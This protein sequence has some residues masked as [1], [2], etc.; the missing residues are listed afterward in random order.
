MLTAPTRRPALRG[1]VPRPR[2]RVIPQ[3]SVV[4]P[5]R[6][7]QDNVAPLLNR[8]HTALGGTP[9]EV[10]FVDDSDDDT[11]QAVDDAA[12]TYAGTTTGVTMVHR[13]REQREGGLS[14]AVISGF[15]A[16]RAPWVVVMDADLQHPPEVVPQLLRAAVDESADL[17]V[18]SRYVGD[19]DATGLS[20]VV[21]SLVSI[22]SGRLAKA[23]FPRRLKHISDPMSGL[24][25][26]RRDALSLDSFNPIGFKILLELAVRLA[27]LKVVEVPFVFAERQAGE[28]KASLREGLRFARHLLRL[29]TSVSG[30]WFRASGVAAVGATG[31][32]LNTAA[33]WVLVEAAG[34]S[35]ALAAL[36]ATQLSSTWNFVLADRFVYRHQRASSWG[37]SLAVFLGINNLALLVRVPLMTLLIA[38]LA[39]DYRI[40]N[41]ATLLLAFAVRFAVVDRTIYRGESA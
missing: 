21:R 36:I 35:I 19:G 41:V 1:V 34:L 22:G 38:Q 25:L 23:F 31:M 14:G 9:A 30:A 39:M 24:F 12:R 5:T 28:S 11:P 27:P 3:V 37:R 32:V 40:A 7:E 29:R 15:R 18:G 16:A 13:G 33:L 17:V 10:V 20:S 8:L 2:T 26:V 4:V 6:N